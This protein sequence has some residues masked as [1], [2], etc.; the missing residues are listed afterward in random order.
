MM[1]HT[2][3]MGFI[4]AVAAACCAAGCVPS[5]IEGNVVDVH[6][7]ALP[8]VAVSIAGTAKQDLTDALGHYRLFYKPGAVTLSFIKTG[9]TPGRLV[10]DTMDKRLVEATPVQ[11]W[12]LPPRKGV[13]LFQDYRHEAAK[14]VEPEKFDTLNWGVVYGTTRWSEV[15]TADEEPMILAYKMPLEGARLVRLELLD[16]TPREDAETA[17]L[18]E[19]WIPT[20]RYD[21]QVVPVDQ[22][23]QI[24]SHLKLEGALEPGCYALHWGAL[25]GEP[26]LESRMFVFNIT[27]FE[28]SPLA[29]P[30]EDESAMPAEEDAAPA[31]ETAPPV[32]PEPAEDEE[33]G[34]SEG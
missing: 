14:P 21:V 28:L 29:P 19:A 7:E 31:E 12:A 5:R 15:E 25:D 13:Y 30:Q 17:K 18:V 27:G 32:E 23:E 33:G 2:R 24:L 3:H 1:H 16:I 9:Y 26:S 4:L 8:G 10:I 22:P 34:P 11:L 6:G 20:K